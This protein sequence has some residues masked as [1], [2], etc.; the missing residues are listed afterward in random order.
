MKNRPL[1]GDIRY[2]DWQKKYTALRTSVYF[3]IVIAVFLAGLI[4]TKTRNNVLTVVAILGVLPASKSFVNTLMY[5]RFKGVDEQFHQAM[6][7]FEEHMHIFYNMLVS[8][9]DK[10]NFINCIAIFDHSVYLFSTED[11]TDAREFEKY[12]K[13]ILSNHG[14]GNVN[15]KLY[16]SQKEFLNRLSALKREKGETRNEES[17]KKIIDIIGPFCL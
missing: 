16:K 9:K 10:I 3:L 6:Q 8:S 7:P 5:I 14:K 12:M 15:V 2:L 11:K 4:T 13:N 17:E 1:K